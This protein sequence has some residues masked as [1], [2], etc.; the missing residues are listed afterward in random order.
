[1]PRD[2]SAS[3]KPLMGCVE[4]I[5]EGA[6]PAL[7]FIVTIVN[8]R[9]PLASNSSSITVGLGVETDLCEGFAQC[10]CTTPS[11]RLSWR[12]CV[13]EKVSVLWSHP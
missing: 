7:G 8:L 13:S 4:S 1:M 2:G 10:S 6:D 12:V 3:A 11:C 9:E 5:L